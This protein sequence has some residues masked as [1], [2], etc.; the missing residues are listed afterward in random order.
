MIKA[1]YTYIWQLVFSRRSEISSSRKIEQLFAHFHLLYSFLPPLLAHLHRV[2]ISRKSFA[3]SQELIHELCFLQFR[4][5]LLD[6]GNVAVF[7]A[8][9]IGELSRTEFTEHFLY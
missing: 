3:R 8:T 1:P 6:F 4:N 7:K 9:K 5:E 2:C